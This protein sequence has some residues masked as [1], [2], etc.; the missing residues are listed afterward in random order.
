MLYKQLLHHL[1][2][3]N[4]SI[5]TDNCAKTCYQCVAHSWW[6]TRI[7]VFN[8]PLVVSALIFWSYWLRIEICNCSQKHQQDLVWP[9]SDIYRFLD[10]E[11]ILKRTIRF[12]A[13]FDYKTCNVLLALDQQSPNIAAGVHENR[14]EDEVGAGD[15]V[16]HL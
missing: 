7:Y 1:F 3:Y 8:F 9:L 5:K 15:Q 12:Y 10:S 14:N 11:L 6:T 16:K 2:I 13:G 4:C